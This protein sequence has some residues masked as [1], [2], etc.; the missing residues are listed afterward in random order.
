MVRVKR[1][2]KLIDEFS[3]GERGD[4][5]AIPKRDRLFEQG[6]ILDV[7]CFFRI[8]DGCFDEENEICEPAARR[9][10][11]TFKEVDSHYT[12]TLGGT[13]EIDDEENDALSN[14]QVMDEDNGQE[15]SEE[16]EPC[17]GDPRFVAIS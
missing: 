3:H 11:E 6:D 4:K 12:Y 1:V 10:L 16:G 7:F 2:A 14:M 5:N 15:G 13:T 8:V 17:D 9:A